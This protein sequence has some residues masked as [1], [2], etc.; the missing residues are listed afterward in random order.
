MGEES[1]EQLVEAII[2]NENGE[3]LEAENLG[4]GHSQSKKTRAKI[5]SK[6]KGKDNP[7]WNGGVHPTYQRRIKGLKKGDGKIVHHTD[8]NRKHNSKKNLKVVS[9]PKHNKLHHRGKNFTKN[10]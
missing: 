2:E 8:G 6:M 7:A 4:Y 5:S 1:D 10:K 3:I 9:A